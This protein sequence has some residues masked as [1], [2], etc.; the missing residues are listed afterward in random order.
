M[1]SDRL[2]AFLACL[3]GIVAAVMLAACG[4]SPGPRIRVFT[5]TLSSAEEVPRT[6]SNAIGTGLVTVDLDTMT[7]TAS[8]VTSG[9]AD[10]SAAIHEG[11]FGTNGPVLFPLARI[12]GSP[13]WTG[14]A[15][16]S[17]AQLRALRR[18]AYYFNVQSAAFPAGEMRGQIIEQ[19]PSS[20]EWAQLNQARQLS[21]QLDQ[22]LWLLEHADDFRDWR[23]SGIGW[24]FTIGF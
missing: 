4:G 13:V 3:L 6:A 16:I 11:G 14:G 22:Q 10:S 17:D 12:S 19:L 20:D 23:F 1:L 8:I 5:T 9:S 24:G 18:Q 21:P 15:M 2:P 7:M